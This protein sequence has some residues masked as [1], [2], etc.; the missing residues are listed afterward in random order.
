MELL[1]LG[2]LGQVLSLRLLVIQL[3]RRPDD[4]FLVRRGTP[5]Y[6]DR[7]RRERRHRWVLR[8]AITA[9]LVATAV[10]ISGLVLALRA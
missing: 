2:V 3:A 7:R 1:L 10:A 5:G 9:F 4:P 6:L 8:G